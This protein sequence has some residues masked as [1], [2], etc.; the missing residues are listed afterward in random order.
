MR[1]PPQPF[2]RAILWRSAVIWLGVRL[3]A[4]AVVR[5]VPEMPGI[6]PSPPYAV[7]PQVIVAVIL[8]ATGLTWLD[9]ARHNEILFFTN[10]GVSRR[11]LLFLAGLLPVVCS[12]TVA[13]LVRL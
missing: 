11:T 6:E 4:T 9:C 8:L 2:V 10:L 3:A 1:L 5:M 7:A 12:V 13:L